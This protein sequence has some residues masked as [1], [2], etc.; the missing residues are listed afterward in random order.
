MTLGALPA[1]PQ[2]RCCRCGGD[3]A[4]LAD[5]SRDIYCPTHRLLADG[6]KNVRPSVPLWAR[7]FAVYRPRSL[8][9]EDRKRFALPE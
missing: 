9:R 1:D 2:T 7:G 8:S 3:A 6:E 4:R 5:G